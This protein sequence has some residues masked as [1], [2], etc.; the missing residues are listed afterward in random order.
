M[1]TTIPDAEP[2]VPL[3]REQRRHPKLV[4][5]VEEAAELISVGRTTLFTLIASGDIE[6]YTEGRRRLI[7]AEALDKYVAV[8]RAKQAEGGAA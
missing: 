5:G 1:T 8:R 7:P 4:Y 6:S 2:S 3:N